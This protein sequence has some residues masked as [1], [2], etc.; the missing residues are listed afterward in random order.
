MTEIANIK[1]NLTA[2]EEKLYNILWPWEVDKKEKKEDILNEIREIFD[3]NIED[4]ILL[5]KW[6]PEI[7]SSKESLIK[8]W[9]WENPSS[10]KE[11]KI[12]EII[13]QLKELIESSKKD[14]EKLNQQTQNNLV[15]YIWER[16]L[17]SSLKI[18]TKKELVIMLLKSLR[19]E[20]N[21]AIEGWVDDDRASQQ[22]EHIYTEKL[23]ED[24]LI[25][26]T[27]NL[28]ENTDFLSIYKEFWNK[29][30]EKEFKKLFL[31]GNY[32]YILKK[33]KKRLI[34]LMKILD[35]N[36]SKEI[37]H[38][39][40]LRDKDLIKKA[41]ENVWIV[42]KKDILTTKVID[43]KEQN[44]DDKKIISE[45]KLE[46]EAK[47][48]KKVTEKVEYKDTNNI[49]N[50]GKTYDEIKKEKIENKTTIYT[51]KRW[52]SLRQ[53]VLDQLNQYNLWEIEKMISETKKINNIK[54]EDEI[55]E[56]QIIKLPN[57]EEVKVKKW[58]SLSL[59]IFEKIVKDK[60][61]YKDLLEKTKSLNKNI[62]YDKLKIWQKI[63]LSVL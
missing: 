41:K 1:W 60:Y 8:K 6:L 23:I 50:L 10:L 42:E 21:S 40:I 4:D 63:K 43:K 36:N 52:D 14:R 3:N 33:D 24:V 29:E 20:I 19:N 46:N 17:E 5:E 26:N 51:V 61:D 28:I 32:F 11:W 35:K 7:M 18:K 15:E 16:N 54:N 57:Q 55:Y 53:I 49:N 34:N 13:N 59:I 45:K 37:L 39:I 25:E 38:E 48:V 56:K 22:L 47:I 44:I 31:E 9:L 2:R 30:T 58:G 62:D 12:A 27:I